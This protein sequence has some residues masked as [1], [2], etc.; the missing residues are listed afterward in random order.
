MS[1]TAKTEKMEPDFD[2]SGGLLPTVAQDAETGEILMLAYM[3]RESFQKTLETG[4]VH[5]WSRSR[6]E[7]WHKGDG[8]GHVQ[9]VKSIYLDCDQ[10]AIVVK[11]EQVGGVACHTG[12]RSCFHFRHVSGNDYEVID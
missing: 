11:I 3:N 8:S 4:Q 2:K 10:D 9:I 12:Q 1:E 6:K 5:Y 7:L